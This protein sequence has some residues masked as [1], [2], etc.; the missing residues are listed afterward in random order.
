MNKQIPILIPCSDEQ[1]EELFD[2]SLKGGALKIMPDEKQW[3]IANVKKKY[4][5]YRIVS[6]NLN[7]ENAEWELTIT[8]I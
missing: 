8:P 1:I 6:A 5:T 4:P 7:I 3:M 2:Y